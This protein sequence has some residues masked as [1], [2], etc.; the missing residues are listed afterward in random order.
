MNLL[1][2]YYKCMDDWEDER[3][4][5]AKFYANRIREAAKQ[6]AAA[7]PRQAAVILE[8][9]KA[10]KEAEKNPSADLDSLSAC[11]GRLMSELFVWKE[12]EWSDIL[13]RMGYFL[14]KYIYIL[15]AYED[16]EEDIKKKCFNPLISYLRNNTIPGV[17]IPKSDSE[18][19]T[20]PD[21]DRESREDFDS[22]CRE[23]LTMMMA[24]CSEAYEV[25]PI[26]K[27]KDIL[28]NILYSGVWA[29]FEAVYQKHRK[30]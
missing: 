13:R 6:T 29:K 1:L 21:F 15:D 10:L 18:S 9:L 30:G 8:E 24:E 23:M 17:K 26:I 28:D 3:K 2:T 19:C 16:L 5:S 4:A 22:W 25:L 27:D 11:F 12:D 7:Y 20:V 14:G